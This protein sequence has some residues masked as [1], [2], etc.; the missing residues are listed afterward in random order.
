M[1]IAHECIGTNT[2]T[3]RPNDKISMTLEM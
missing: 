2:V 1:E 3:N